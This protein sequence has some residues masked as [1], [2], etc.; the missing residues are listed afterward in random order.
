MS[1]RLKNIE[2]WKCSHL[3]DFTTDI[4]KEHVLSV[5]CG[6]CGTENVIDLN[7]YRDK[8]ETSLKGGN[9]DET[10]SYETGKYNFPAKIQGHEPEEQKE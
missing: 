6:I 9:E 1:I 5:Y 4:P 8:T 10:A 7:P 2:C 3:F